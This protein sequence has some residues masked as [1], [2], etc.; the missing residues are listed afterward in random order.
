[1]NAVITLELKKNLQDR[2]LLFWALI[3][4]I[5]FTVL[6][7]S[8]FTSGASEQESREIILS[9]VPGYT[10]MFVFFIMISMTESFLKDSKIGMVARIAGTPLP[11]NLY[12]LGKWI[13]YVYCIYTDYGFAFVWKIGLSNSAGAALLFDCLI[14]ASYVYGY[15]DWIGFGR[16]RK[17]KQYGNCFDTGY[18]FGRGTARGTLGAR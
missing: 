15:R 1:M 7:I 16:H 2:G 13:S 4:P 18:R 8:V 11:S 10:I 14:F 3:L 6:F 9:I 12:L 17:N 5:I